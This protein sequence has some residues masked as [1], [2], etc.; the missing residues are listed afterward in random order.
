MVKKNISISFQ[1]CPHHQW[2]SHGADECRALL[3]RT[4]NSSWPAAGSGLQ[5]GLYC[6]VFS[7]SVS[8]IS[9]YI[10]YVYCCDITGWDS[11]PESLQS[12]PSTLGEAGSR[13]RKWMNGIS[14]VFFGQYFVTETNKEAFDDKICQRLICQLYVKHLHR[15]CP[16]KK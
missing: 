11:V 5:L 13:C 3:Q 1:Q 9:F 8:F 4:M 6:W 16:W 10:L 12:E 2:C 7:T 14:W 15:H